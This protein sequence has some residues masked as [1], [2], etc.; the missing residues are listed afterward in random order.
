MVEGETVEIINSRAGV[1]GGVYNSREAD[2]DD[3]NFKRNAFGEIFVGGDSGAGF[4][5]AGND[6]SFKITSN[7]SVNVADDPDNPDVYEAM[8][9]LRSPKRIVVGGYGYTLKNAIGAWTGSTDNMYVGDERK[10]DKLL[11]CSLYFSNSAFNFVSYEDEAI[12][13]YSFLALNQKVDEEGDLV[14]DTEAS[15]YSKES[16]IAAGKGYEEIYSNIGVLPVFGTPYITYNDLIEDYGMFEE[17][18]F[19]YVG[20]SVGDRQYY[21]ENNKYGVYEEAIFITRSEMQQFEDGT[22]QGDSSYLLSWLEKNCSNTEKITI[23]Y[24]ENLRQETC[25]LD[26]LLEDIRQ[27]SCDGIA[28]AGYLTHYQHTLKAV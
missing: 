15:V 19:Q 8:V 6:M 26:Y 7:G 17:L 3:D 16:F 10:M 4:N 1:S 27:S 9:V 24:I 18:E 11:F 5:H 2:N 20:L 12:Y 14:K 23:S 21:I 22:Q 28:Y 13:R 25:N